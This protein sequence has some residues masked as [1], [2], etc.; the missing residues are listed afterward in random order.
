MQSAW[1]WKGHLSADAKKDTLAMGKRVWRLMNVRPSPTPA[2]R[3]PSAEIPQDR[4]PVLVFMDS[5]AMERIALVSM[6]AS[7][8][9]SVT[10]K[11]HAQIELVPTP[12]NVKKV[13]QVMVEHVPT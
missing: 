4:L 3:R 1:I 10:K 9:M 2:A 5:R 7:L 6:N 8:A 13:G 11:Q 12:A